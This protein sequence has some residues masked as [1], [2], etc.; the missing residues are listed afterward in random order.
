M[1]AKGHNRMMTVCLCEALG[2]CLFVW[3]IMNTN[4]CTTIPFSLLAS[5]V[6]WGDITGG[7]FNPAVTL[8]VYISLGEYTAGEQTIPQ[9]TLLAFARL[10][11]FPS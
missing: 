7:H 2:T 1:E 6:I 8:G 5:V 3:G 10:P 9:L 11:I 4:L